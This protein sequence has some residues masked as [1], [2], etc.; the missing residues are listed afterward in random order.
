MSTAWGTLGGEQAPH[1]ISDLT[2][3]GSSSGRSGGVVELRVR[4]LE[5][6][7][8]ERERC[9]RN[10][11]YVRRERQISEAAV[12]TE[13]QLAGTGSVGW[14]R[15]DEEAQAEAIRTIRRLSQ[16]SSAEE[17]AAA[18]SVEL[19]QRLAQEQLHRSVSAR[20]QVRRLEAELDSK[21]SAM[22]DLRRT[23]ESRD[24]ELLQTQQQVRRLLWQEMQRERDEK[25]P[26][27]VDF[28]S[29]DR[30]KSLRE[31]VLDLEYQL[32]LKD[33]EIGRL[34]HNALREDK[35]SPAA[36]EESTFC[37]SERSTVF[38]SASSA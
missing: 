1:S 33:L 27:G 18:G 19:A 29:Y 21:E 8:R 36:D 32:H 5:E 16:Q 22:Q 34:S 11:D 6:A 17:M 31:Q 30:V 37:G 24:K 12:Q 14:S 28:F 38:R 7:R 20:Q 10:P 23:L 26:P 35:S 13:P 25:P 2:S 3:V 9:L 4:L 15:A